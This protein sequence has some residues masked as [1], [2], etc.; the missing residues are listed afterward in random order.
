METVYVPS[1]M[2]GPEHLKP[3]GTFPIYNYIYM[4]TAVGGRCGITYVYSSVCH[5]VIDPSSVRYKHAVVNITTNVAP[6]S[7]QILEPAR[8][9]VLDLLTHNLTSEDDSEGFRNYP[10]KICGLSKKLPA[11]ASTRVGCMLDATG[12]NYAPTAEDARQ[13]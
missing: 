2:V 4:V 10:P 3:S 9:A 5:N 11:K 6:E 12:R 13:V 7:G 8:T 1:P